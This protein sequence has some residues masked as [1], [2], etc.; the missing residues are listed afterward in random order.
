MKTRTPRR[1]RP[2]VRAAGVVDAAASASDGEPETEESA[3]VAE[4]AARK[5]PAVGQDRLGKLLGTQAGALCEDT[6]EPLLPVQIPVPSGLHDAV[7]VEDEG[8]AGLELG[9][10]GLVV[11]IR[12]DAEGEPA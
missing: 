6:V 4:I 9:A 5:G 1:V 2:T 8:R 10:L 3:I 12:L 11:L 7:R